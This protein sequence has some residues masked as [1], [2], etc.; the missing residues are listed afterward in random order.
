MRGP[1]GGELIRD[2]AS[3]I[4]ET[5]KT[6]AVEKAKKALEER[7]YENKQFRTNFEILDQLGITYMVKPR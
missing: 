1:R 6:A 2:G 4:F 5:K 7:Y 3:G